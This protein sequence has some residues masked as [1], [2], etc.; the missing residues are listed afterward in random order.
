MS[1]SLL[2]PP[3]PSDKRAE[4]RLPCQLVVVP[5]LSA[6]AAINDHWESTIRDL[7]PG[8][9]GLLLPEELEVGTRLVVELPTRDGSRPWELRVVRSTRQPNGRWLHGCE[10]ATELTQ[11]EMLDALLCGPTQFNA[12]VKDSP[13]SISGV[14]DDR[15]VVFVR[16]DPALHGTTAEQPVAS[17]KTQAEAKE[18]Q[19]Q[20]RSTGADCVIRYA[21]PA[22]GGD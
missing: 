15:F 9:V 5:Y 14:P 18:V 7:A 16:P 4:V 8:G 13:V 19:Q 12:G 11:N 6:G 21:G 17:C 10:A 22:G 3:V 1:H 2:Q 20:L